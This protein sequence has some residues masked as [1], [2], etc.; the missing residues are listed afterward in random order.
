MPIQPVL[1]NGSWREPKS[2][3]GHFQSITPETGVA[4]AKRYPIS[5]FTDIELAL[6]A[7]YWAVKE[8]KSV[9]PENIAKF[10]ELY[11]SNIEAHAA[12]LS[13][14]AAI[15]T[16]LPEKS[17]FLDIELP[18]TTDQLRKAA[19]AAKD[20]SWCR[21]TIDTKTN[22]R[23]KF[24][25][26]G[27]PVV[28]FGPN[29]FPFAFNSISGG[30][31]AAAIASG[32][33]VIAK[34]NPGHPGTTR[35]FA[36]VALKALKKCGLP[37]TMI[38]LIYHLQPEDGFKL[39]S[40]PLTGA[41]AFTGS[42]KSGLALKHAAESAGKLIYIEMSGLNPVFIFPLALKERGK[43]IAEELSQSCTLGAGQ[44]CTNPGLVVLLKNQDTENFIKTLAEKLRSIPAGILLSRQVL[45]SLAA[46]IALLKKFGAEIVSGGKKIN[47]N[48]FS[49][50]NTLLRVTGDKFL[51]NSKKLQTETF[52]PSSLIVVAENIKQMITIANHLEGNLTG[53]I[54]SH[55]D[56]KEES[57]YA[58]IEA[59][60]RTKVGRL[61][62]DKMPTG[63]A[64][65]PAMSHGG[66]FPATGHPG[67][68]SVGIPAAMLRFS[69]L[70]CYDNVR[71]HRL[72]AE[73]KD[74]N[75]YGKMWRLIDGDWTQKNI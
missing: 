17:R 29:N 66:P 21:A 54:Y 65:S 24:S 7:S 10:L 69:A 20:R 56:K 59:I 42:R 53:S 19:R 50:A 55:T 52:G 47:T 44:F 11:A 38:Q 57:L 62:N 2:P 13:Q 31:F 32:N 1:I 28:I 14:T 4:Q 68:T 22:I 35:I 63:V 39:V 58:E 64:V 5:S 48:A 67:F 3:I 36:E 51:K 12:L 46:A 34:A 33:P 75:P 30:D 71:K 61:I 37:L 23:S 18:R 70:H 43:E 40:H 45:E 6:S 15:E 16:A 74:K 49:F 73:L 9:S 25:P 27:G 8:L 26:L 72:P 60:L 41:T